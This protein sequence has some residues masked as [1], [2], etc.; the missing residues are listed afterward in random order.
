[1]Q[2][3]IDNYAQGKQREVEAWVGSK[4]SASTGRFICPECLEAVALDIRGHFRHKNRTP[5]SLECDKRVDSPSRSAHER[6]GLPLYL[7]EESE[8]HFTLGIGFSGHDDVSLEKAT[9]TQAYFE[10]EN[11]FQQPTRYNISYARF[12]PNATTILPIKHLPRN[13]GS[14]HIKYSPTTPPALRS[15]WTDHSDVWGNGQFFK[16][17]ESK[18]RKIRPLGTV[19]T[20][21]DYYYIGSTRLLSNYRSFVFVSQAGLLSLRNQTLSVYKLKIVKSKASEYQFKAFTELLRN[22]YKINLLVDES[23]LAPVWPPCLEED[24]RIIYPSGTA[25]AHFH[26]QT[27]NDTPV[28]YRY[29]GGNYI[30][31]EISGKAPYTSCITL[32]NEDIPICVDRAFNG[33]IQFICRSSIKQAAHRLFAD[34]VNESGISVRE[35]AP[36]TLRGKIFRCITN[37]PAMVHIFNGEKK[38]LCREITNNDGLLLEHCQ[39]NDTICIFTRN[40]SLVYQYS[41]EKA[42]AHGHA[43]QESIDPALLNSSL[44]GP[45]ERITPKILALY[46]STTDFTVKAILGKYIRQGSIPCRLVS[47]LLRNY[48]RK[49]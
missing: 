16:I 28:L 48:R 41:F 49:A 18:H 15:I 21:E 44:T 7:C 8:G 11:T 35:S 20:D 37:F 26:I 2:K 36:A 5:Q 12:L 24:N 38:D 27:P 25:A 32:T 22:Y 6:M 47:L 45:S 17:S 40:G 3:A 13:N 10:I 34:I 39:W 43:T 42:T 33:N 19:V 1:M 23:L 29:F 4:I 46:K 9:S 31:D 30:L 14:F